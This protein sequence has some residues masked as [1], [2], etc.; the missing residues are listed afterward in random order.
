ML[1][2]AGTTET[3]YEQELKKAIDYL[4]SG[5]RMLDEAKIPAAPTS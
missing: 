3:N 1:I 5:Q 2:C 4:A